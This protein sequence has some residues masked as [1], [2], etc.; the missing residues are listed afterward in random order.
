MQNRLPFKGSL[1]QD[2]RETETMIVPPG[3]VR[4][5]SAAATSTFIRIGSSKK[6]A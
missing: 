4:V 2:L 3:A 1:F 5:Y 6:T